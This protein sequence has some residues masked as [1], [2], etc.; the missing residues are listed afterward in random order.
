MEPA[1][2]Y[3]N[4]AELRRLI[5]YVRKTFD[6]YPP[7]NDDTEQCINVVLSYLEKLYR[8]NT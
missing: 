3:L 6:D 7:Q 8:E 2:Q 1:T 4:R 5:I